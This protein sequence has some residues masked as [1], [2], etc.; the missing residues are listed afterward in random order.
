MIFRIGFEDK[1]LIW[2]QTYVR[3]TSVVTVFVDNTTMNV[4]KLPALSNTNGKLFGGEY[5]CA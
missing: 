2:F 5:H 4:H 1:G 3:K